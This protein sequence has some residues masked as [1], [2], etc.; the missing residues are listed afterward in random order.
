MFLYRL[1]MAGKRF[2]ATDDAHIPHHRGNSGVRAKIAMFSSSSDHVA[3]LGGGHLANRYQSSEDVGR[4]GTGSAIASS[5]SITAASMIRAHTQGDVRF[6][7]GLRRK[8]QQGPAAA[9][10]CAASLKSLNGSSSA[11]LESSSDLIV[12]GQEH[13]QQQQQQQQPLFTNSSTNSGLRLH[14]KNTSAFRSMIN[15]SSTATPAVGDMLPSSRENSAEGKKASS[16]SDLTREASGGGLRGQQQHHGVIWEE[17]G[18]TNATTE[19][20]SVGGSSDGIG[21][22]SKTI[23]SRSQSL[24]EIGLGTVTKLPD[25]A[26]SD[27]SLG[28]SRSSNLLLSSSS[29]GGQEGGAATAGTSGLEQRRRS[30]MS[31]LKGLVIPETREDNSAAHSSSS[32]DGCQAGGQT[33]HEDSKLINAPGDNL[34]HQLSHP[35]WK[36]KNDSSSSILE[37]FPKYSPAFKRKPFTV[38]SNTATAGNNRP[39]EV[40][41]SNNCKPPIGK[42]FSDD[43]SHQPAAAMAAAWKQE[44]S[45][46]DSAV[47]SGRSSLSGRSSSPPAPVAPATTSP[48]S[49]ARRDSVAGAAAKTRSSPLKQQQPRENNSSGNPRVL[50]KNSVEAINRQN[51][52]NACKKRSATPNSDIA[53]AET[54]SG[55]SPLE[56]M[57]AGRGSSAFGRPASR[58]S[59]F[60]QVAERKKSFETTTAANGTDMSVTTTTTAATDAVLPA[61]ARRGSNSSQDSLSRRSS[62]DGPDT[63]SSSLLSSSR[64]FS[65]EAAESGSSSSVSSRRGSRVVT[66]T[67]AANSSQYH[68]PAGGHSRSNSN[69]SYTNSYPGAIVAIEEKVAY[70][71]DVVDRA[72]SITP[73]D[74]RRSVSRTNSYSSSR[75]SRN[76]SIVSEKAAALP[77]A[78]NSS[79]SS[80]GLNKESNAHQEKAIQEAGGATQTNAEKASRKNSPATTT[81]TGSGGT[82][83]W[84]EL[85]RKYS[86]T[87]AQQLQ[88]QQSSE[89]IG[90]KISRL[91]SR[92]T[93]EDAGPASL[94]STSMSSSIGGGGAGGK[95][96]GGERPK[97]LALQK[98]LSNGVLIS[99][100]GTLKNFKELAEKWQTI[101]VETPT[102]PNGGG[103]GGGFSAATLPRKSSKEKSPSPAVTPTAATVSATMPRR[104]RYVFFNR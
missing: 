14:N 4:A 65:H 39:A 16:I 26:V 66:P 70:M 83:K 81:V 1:S 24:N 37:D 78:N 11:L 99:S 40:S 59:S 31:K 104:S 25:Q 44:D 2:S 61:S 57:T 22:A 19:K 87:G 63:M 47:S 98:K 8:Q 82:D 68:H 88:H 52:I 76:S 53:V 55:S 72:A 62:R 69:S 32:A 96:S 93:G 77:R 13:K 56:T 103:V 27:V 46:N 89:S 10:R 80:S 9:A 73:T 90:D 21:G 75:S 92:T 71:T 43:G 49:A 74:C 58:S 36:E 17:T 101:A 29:G 91:K 54:S 45:D 5:A 28:R 64:R 35:P 33:V 102:T 18:G 86:K 23:N 95:I 97:D 42:R 51:V 79:S 94:T 34:H 41:N 20:T 60:N 3:Y 100:P 12:I 67:T 48:R 84:S 30:T 6:E 50:K 85:E 15:V 7:D 38:Y